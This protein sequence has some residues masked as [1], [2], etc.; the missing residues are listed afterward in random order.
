M[1][2]SHIVL[3]LP[4]VRQTCSSRSLLTSLHHFYSLHIWRVD[5][6]PHL[7]TN[8]CKLVAE[9]NSSVDASA[10]DVDTDAC[11]WIAVFL[12]DE[13]DISDLGCLRAGF[14]EECCACPGRV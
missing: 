14:A 5:L 10:A 1:D 2:A 8:P 9:E 12:A 7:H 4:H 6:I 13:E 11:E 3:W